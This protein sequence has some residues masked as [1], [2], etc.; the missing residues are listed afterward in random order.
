MPRNRPNTTEIV[1]AVR[2]CLQQQVLPSCV[3]GELSLNVRICMSLLNT[4]ERELQSGGSFDCQEGKILAQLLKALVPEKHAEIDSMSTT[5]LNLMLLEY[6]SNKPQACMNKAI[7][8]ALYEI[9]LAK[10]A[11]DNPK[12]PAFKKLQAQ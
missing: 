6:I 1:S 8:E 7:I 2:E 5:E 10:I 3:D 9:T 11:V 4:V 12:Y